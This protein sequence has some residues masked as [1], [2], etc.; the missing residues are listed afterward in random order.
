MKLYDN[1]ALSSYEGCRRRFYFRHIMHLTGEGMA[2]APSFGISWHAA[3][4]VVWKM[5]DSG[6]HDDL[7][8]LKT[9]YSAFDV[10]WQELGFPGLNEITPDQEEELK[11]RTPHTAI[12]MLEA[13]I[14]TRRSLISRFKVLDCERPFVVPLPVG[15][16]GS[17]WYCGRLDKTLEGDA[18][19]YIV[20]HKT[21]S[22]Y[23]KDGYFKQD[24]IDS[25][26]PD[27]QVDGY[28]FAAH[29][30]FENDYRALYIDGALV[31]RTVHEGFCWIPVNRHIDQLDGWLA[32]TTSR[33][34]DVEKEKE[35]LL[36]WRA[37]GG[38]SSPYMPLFR[39]NTNA[40]YDFFTPC[41]YLDLCKGWANPDRA[42][43]EQ[44]TPPGFVREPWSPFD[45]IQLEKLGFKREDAE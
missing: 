4:D 31:H 45:H 6:E 14:P 34:Q 36:I 25:F 8:I 38:H 11:S 33:V 39:K 27:N 21:T 1:T 7:A 9:A 35:D 24:F 41:P 23:K 17:L 12:G 26:S 19:K 42:L 40:C 3:M 44:G 32:E 20:D 15:E 30:L 28:A 5:I 22:A 43:A 29:I 16:P 13:Y 2:A 10:R 18:G 37:E